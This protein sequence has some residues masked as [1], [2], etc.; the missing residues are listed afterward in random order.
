MFVVDDACRRLI[1][2][3]IARAA[4]AHLGRVDRHFP[5]PATHQDDQ[6]RGFGLLIHVLP[7]PVTLGAGLREGALVGCFIVRV[8]S[9][10]DLG[11]QRD[12]RRRGVELL[13]ILA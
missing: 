6:H 10:D 11:R 2:Q 5:R 12:A 7:H 8:P 13:G 4:V 3:F 9:A 1:V